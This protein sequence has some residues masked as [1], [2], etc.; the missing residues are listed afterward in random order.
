MGGRKVR[1]DKRIHKT[2]N[3]EELTNVYVFR[4]FS[5]VKAA[6]VWVLMMAL[7]FLFAQCAVLPNTGYGRPPYMPHPWVYPMPT[8]KPSAGAASHWCDQLFLRLNLF[9]LFKVSKVKLKNYCWFMKNN[10][11]IHWNINTCLIKLLIQFMIFKNANLTLV[12]T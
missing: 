11:R 5:T 12:L 7:C 6:A 3:L 8:A 9:S 4:M 10:K 1:S 2:Y